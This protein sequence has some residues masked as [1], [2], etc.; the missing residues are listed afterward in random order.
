ML[1]NEILTFRKFE[2]GKVSVSLTQ[3]NLTALIQ[4]VADTFKTLTEQKNI[5]FNIA[6]DFNLENVWYDK[7]K[8]ENILFNLLSNAI[9]YTPEKGKIYFTA[10]KIFNSL[11]K[12]N[13]LINIQDNG[14]GISKSAQSKVFDRFYRDDSEQANG[15]YGTGI[16]LALTKQMVEVLNGK[17]TLESEIN[18]GSSFKVILPLEKDDFPT[19]DVKNKDSEEQIS[20]QERV[21]LMSDLNVV[22]SEQV[23]PLNVKDDNSKKVLVVEDNTDLREFLAEAL[24]VNYTVS[25]AENGEIGYGLAC[26]NDYDLI[27]SDI[28]MPKVNGLEL[29]K[30]LKNNLQTSHIPVILL[31]AKNQ[32]ED[33]IE[34]LQYGADDYISK[35]FNLNVLQAKIYSIIENR[36]KLIQR[37]QKVEEDEEQSVVS[38]ISTLDQEFMN[39]V[40]QVIEEFYVDSA[41][42]IDAFS[43]KL[44]VSRSLL[45]KKLK[46]LTDVSPNE[47]ITI[48]RLK[49]S[50]TLLKSNKHQVSE[51]A[52]MV[53]F[54]D[55]KYFS[56]VFKKY[57]NCSPSSYLE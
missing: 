51:V 44:Y 46:A 6:V 28:M 14:I 40:N 47:Y 49:K 39:K 1:T 53:G 31:T 12:P 56:R 11:N 16:G 38:N 33:Y 7:G 19:H 34:G 9:K 20:L 37:F 18:K 13:V 21:L 43:S 22:D 57:Y 35:P 17:I 45:Y 10:T 30:M 48:Y 42:D 2:A 32:E 26:E 8:L 54:N 41:F 23:Q 15:S 27:V 55:P 52:F 25:V 4:G 36:E 5:A 3:G 50:L 24:S 29:C